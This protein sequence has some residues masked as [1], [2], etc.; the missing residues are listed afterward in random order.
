MG[1]LG[2]PHLH[3]VV[4]VLVVEDEGLLDELVLLLEQV[5]V[6]LV[7]H[8]A[9]L[10]PLQVV[11]LVLQGPVH[12]DGDAPDL[13]HRRR[14]QLAGG[15]LLLA[16]PFLEACCSLAPPGPPPLYKPPGGSV[17]AEAGQA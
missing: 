2:G 11:Q 14:E 5:E 12:L 4:G 9:A 16:S 8:D 6:R 10:V 1:V 13:L 3:G 15:G 17:W 7:V